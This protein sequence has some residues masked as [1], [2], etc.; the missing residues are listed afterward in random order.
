MVVGTNL[1]PTG[2]PNFGGS[3][4]RNFIQWKQLTCDTQDCEE[5]RTGG[6][7]NS[8]RAQP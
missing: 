4:D 2:I 8:V 6:Q 1:M 3:E 7:L 5:S